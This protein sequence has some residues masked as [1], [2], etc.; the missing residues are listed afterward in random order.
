MTFEELLAHVIAV[1]QREGRISYR[2][3]QRRFDLDDAY[4][5]DVKVELIEAKQLARDENGRILVWAEQAATTAPPP[6]AQEGPP[7]SLPGAQTPQ[8]ASAHVAP[9]VPEAERRQLT[10][11]FCDLVGSTA[12]SRQLDP[13]DYRAVVRAYQAAC[14]SVIGRF[15]GHIAQYL[16]DGLLVYFGYP[17]AHEDDA[18]RAVRAALGCLEALEVLNTRLE[19]DQGIRLAVRLGMHTGLVVVG[20]MG[21]AGRQ[22]QLALGEVPNIAARLQG[23]AEPDTV[24]ISADTYRLIQG[25]FACQTLGNHALRGVSQPIAVYQVLQ[26]SGAQSRLDIA[27]PS[28]LTPL[29]G[30]ESEVLLLLERWAHSQGGGG[31]VVLLSGEA[32]IGKSRLVEVL[33]ERVRSA[34]ATRIVFRCSPYYQNSALYPVI[35]HLQRFLQ[36][37]RDEAPEAKFNTLE[38]V[39]RTSRLPLED[40]LPLF[41]ALLSV[42]VP[43]R[44]P[45]HNL[46]PQRQR[47]KTHEALVAWLLEEAERQPVL[48]VWEDLHWADPST[49]ELLGLVLDQVPTARMLTLLTC[50]PEFHPPWATHSHI[51]QV[52]LTRLG[53][54]PVEAMITSLTGGKALPTAVV[55]QVVAK[56]DGVPLFVEEL[57]KVILESGL[58][59]EEE[60]HYELR[61]PLPPL[62]IPATLHDSLMA[63]LDRLA[64]VKEVAQLA[65]TLG[66]TFSYDLLHAV[67][68]LDEVTLQH[69]LARLVEAELLYQRGLPPQATYIFKHALIQETAYQALLKS[70]RQQY[71]QRIAQV[72]TA[73]FPDIA[74]TQ[75]E[76]LA[77]HYTEAGLNEQA[78]PYWQRAGQQALQRSANLEAGQHLTRGL[79]LLSI[80][81]ETP[82]RAQQELDLQVAL[83]PA[84]M[85][86]RGWAVPEVEQT[87]ARARALCQQVG[88]TP[89]LF[90]TLRGLC[91]F[92]FTRGALPTA[93]ELGEQLY[94]LAQRQATPMP[95]LEA[96]DALGGTLFF[97]G[98]YA[99]ART[100]LEQGI[101][102]TDPTAQQALALRHH[103]A[104]GVWCPAVA[105]NALW[106]LGFPE[107]AVRRSQEAVALARTLAHPQSLVVAQFFAAY[108]HLRRH[109]V[110]EVLEQTEAFLALA[111]E[112][113]LP[114]HMGYGAVW[115]GWVL[116]MQG[117]GDVGLAQMRRGMAAV[118]ATGMDLS[119]SLCLILLAEAAG[120]VGQIA[121]GLHLLVEAVTVMEES[122]RGEML[123]EAYRLQGELHLR[124][125]VPDAVQAE[126]CFQ[127][128]LTLA[129]QQQAKSWELRA[130][131]SLSRLWQC[132]GKRN[133]AHE[134]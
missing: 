67:T 97:Q 77:H 74:E 1:L 104:S 57:T 53:R 87:Y 45:P 89:Q 12:L 27:G 103:V 122:G 40:V 28:G 22:E 32:G 8:E 111:T 126:A 81:P 25:Y 94:R 52:T 56:T 93:R 36:W 95:R 68:P 31:Q 108:L 59:R 84:L 24:L 66:R 4:L 114:L 73:H 48:A 130:A 14:A 101:A 43:E 54:A 39:L 72:L 133:A 106:C 10:V 127:Q 92:Y 46:T 35:D 70:T 23:L 75:P 124:Q 6:T 102:L 21:G 44:Y 60:D 105:A 98:E 49:L 55:E 118:L 30:R 80:L 15:D 64:T 129:R 13:E 2:A 82:Q 113:G 115:R 18:Q 110:P 41:A 3:L 71:H 42:P 90:P 33:C 134:S 83:G 128:A 99:A 17:Q 20:A 51:T 88:E 61:G 121:D 125:T 109:E 116:V 58:L 38:R 86:T 50:R 5:D 16:G 47:Q 63:R 79:D 37:Q 85:A 11:L 19:R 117:Q 7:G 29:A 78:I 96:H 119:R 91:W 69:A 131:M 62:A 100:H 132:Q 112:Q 107:Q 26:E 65:A 76:L 123:T 120:H 34:S 9:S